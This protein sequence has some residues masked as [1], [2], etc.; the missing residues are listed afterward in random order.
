MKTCKKCKGTRIKSRRN[1][2]HGTKSRPI[3]SLVCKDCGSADIEAKV[4]RFKGKRR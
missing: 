1:Y 4:E 2:T 3:T